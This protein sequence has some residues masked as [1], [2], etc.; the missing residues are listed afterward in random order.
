MAIENSNSEVLTVFVNANVVTNVAE[1]LF[2]T[3]EEAL[4][5]AIANPTVGRIELLSDCYIDSII[6]PGNAYELNQNISI[7]SSLG[8]NY[9]V[10]F[11]PTLGMGQKFSFY[12]TSNN[13]SLTFDDNVTFVGLDV[14]ADGYATQNNEMIING[15]VSGLSLKVWTSNNGVTVGSTG[16]VALGHGDG[17]LDLAYGNGY[18]TV[19]GILVNTSD[20]SLTLGPQFK[21]GYAGTRGNG[22]SINLNST[23]FEGG[24]WFTISG[25]NGTINA[26]NSVLKVSGG[27]APGSIS[28]GSN[29]NLIKIEEGSR[30][31]VASMSVGAGNTIEINDSSIEISKKLTNSGTVNV[32]NGIWNVASTANDGSLVVAG[33]TELNGTITGNAIEIADG[34][35]LTTGVNGA[36]VNGANIGE[37]YNATDVSA[38][39]GAG[40]FSFTESIYSYAGGSDKLT[41]AAGA[42]VST[43]ITFATYGNVDVAAN[44]NLSANSFYFN[45]A[46]GVF[47]ISG[48]VT[49]AGND[50]GF[51]L[52]NS[53]GV[54]NVTNGTLNVAYIESTSS[55]A[56]V[57]INVNSSR[58]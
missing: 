31:I 2:A 40:N 21:A 32:N 7:G 45:G 38:T 54:V 51:V 22:N 37:R 5:Y 30:L 41:I 49:A 11:A 34:A 20:E 43:L 48:T 50:G 17:Q 24:A 35:I 53:N 39:F 27:D 10:E 28:V 57:T 16:N 13:T 26:K 55:A 4:I 33:N 6:N 29:G 8:N 52:R 46:E 56:N 36:F 25:S 23:Y 19:N 1:G 44:A 18:L 14:I 42:N 47:N 3:F 58:K 12:T 15:N 9:K